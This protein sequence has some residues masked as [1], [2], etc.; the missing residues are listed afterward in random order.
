MISVEASPMRGPRPA[1]CNELSGSAAWGMAPSRI[2]LLV[3]WS[4][5]LPCHLRRLA[6]ARPG[7][8][9][10]SRR[11][12][13]AETGPLRE[14][15]LCRRRG[16]AGGGGFRRGRSAMDE[17]RG[18][19]VAEVVALLQNAQGVSDD[20]LVGQPPGQKVVA[21][22]AGEDRGRGAGDESG[23]VQLCGHER[24]RGEAYSV[25]TD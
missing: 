2:V 21:Q 23:G 6:L 15:A 9:R 18:V 4:S 1:R 5:A 24:A 14:S 11:R 22:C 19:V 20:Q 17:L 13:A 3:N 16:P 7:S 12:Q 25:R 8:T 10:R